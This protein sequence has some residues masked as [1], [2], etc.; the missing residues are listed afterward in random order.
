[1]GP[2]VQPPEGGPDEGQSAL[3]GPAGQVYPGG[4][5]VHGS[6]WNETLLALTPFLVDVAVW[7]HVQVVQSDLR[8]VRVRS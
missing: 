8:L 5:P 7:V 4:S 6:G 3:S 2:G 1:M